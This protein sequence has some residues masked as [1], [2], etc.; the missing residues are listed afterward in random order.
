MGQ[1]VEPPTPQDAGLPRISEMARSN[2]L[3]LISR[4]LPTAF[5]GALIDIHSPLLS[6]SSLQHYSN[7][8]WTR[9]NTSYPLLHQASFDAS[10]ADAIFLAAIISLGATYS[11]REAHHIAVLLHDNLRPNLFFHV[12]FSSSPDLWVLQTMLL[13][14]CFGKFRAGKK[15]RDMCQLF[16]CVLIKLVRRST[17]LCIQTPP[18]TSQPDD[19]D[20]AWRAVMQLEQRKR[21]AIHCFM[22]DTQHSVLFSQ[23]LCM[24]AFEIR[25]HLPCDSA[26]WEAQTATDWAAAA[27]NERPQCSFLAVL[28]GYISPR[29]TTRPRHLNPL[30]RILL[31]HGLMSVSADLK[32]RDQAVPQ[33]DFDPTSIARP[34]PIRDWRTRISQSYD[35][36]KTD[37]DA[38]FLSMKLSAAET[39]RSSKRSAPQ[40]NLAALKVS[41]HALYHAANISL[42]TEIL[43]LQVGA[44]ATTILGR[45]VTQHDYTRSRR[46]L[47]QWTRDERTK[48]DA[49]RAAWHAGWILRDWV[50]G[51][52]GSSSNGGSWNGTGDAS[53][54]EGGGFWYAWCLYLA[55]VVVWNYHCRLSQPPSQPQSARQQ[56]RIDLNSNT[57]SLLIAMTRR[58]DVKDMAELA[59]K[60]DTRGLLQIVQKRLVEVRWAVVHDAMKVLG[61]LVAGGER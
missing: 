58:Y 40:M 43:D 32:R 51:E 56:Q 52:A 48:E 60:F 36:W 23:S 2:V 11:S 31:L 55:S 7:L 20:E 18:L 12:D 45:S 47:D 8:F 5:D 49:A 22:W 29:K 33:R 13:V 27:R 14:D 19:L 44:G 30:S 3:N 41:T 15:Q 37:F 17:C 42:L 35:L 6:L 16:H 4:S 34:C 53:D 54:E 39:M 38:D 26:V 28:K 10:S 24:S 21:L 25:S 46:A 59:G 57:T 1:S 9:F 61:A 50:G